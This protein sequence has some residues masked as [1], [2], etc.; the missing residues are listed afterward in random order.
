MNLAF[1][2]SLYYPWIDIRDEGWLKSAS[3]YWE[4][5]QTIV[6]RTINSPYSTRTARYLEDEGILIPLRVHS[7]LQEIEELTQD[8]IRYL[9]SQEGMELLT[10]ANR[11]WV[12]IHPEKLPR[13]IRRISKIHPMKLSHEIRHVLLESGLG[14]EE[15]DDFLKVDDRFASFYMTLLATRLSERI[16]AGL[17]TSLSLPHKLSLKA[18]ADSQIGGILNFRERYGYEIY[19]RRGVPR[20][21]TQGMLVELI[22]EEIAIDPET[23][24]EK[25]IKFK[26]RHAAELG[27][28]RS[29]IGEL[30]SSIPE[31]APLP[32]V[33]QYVTD[34]YLNEVK[35]AM[36]ELKNSLKSSRIKW[37]TNSWMKLAFISAGSSSMLMGIGLSTANALLVGAGISLIGS[38]ILYNVNK[39]ESL[40]ANPYS[41]LMTLKNEMP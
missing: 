28:F 34:L 11:K 14:R 7:D 3:L 5:I 9:N 18:K 39:Q 12:Y 36:E 33:R 24:I 41:Y 8:V 13:S 21:L 30:T 35:P 6:P 25:I 26:N 40:R 29:K 27:R 17:I 23:P 31:D 22:I 10:D 16:G 1:T 2:K 4:T 20:E 38:G 37:L 19:E 32:A 15:R